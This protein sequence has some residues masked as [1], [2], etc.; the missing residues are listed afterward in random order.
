MSSSRTF[1]PGLS[2]SVAVLPGVPALWSFSSLSAIESCP[3]RYVL[4]RATYPD[5]WDRSGYPDL[6]SAAALF[7][8]VVHDSLE[9]IVRALVDHGCSSASSREAIAVL[10]KLGGYSEV[11]SSMLAKRLTRLEVNPRLS[12]RVRERLRDQLEQRIPEAREEIQYYLHRMTM[13]PREVI[14]PGSG[15]RNQRYARGVG[16]HPEVTLQADDLRLWGRIDLLTV[17]QVDVDITDY[18]TGTAEDS[19]FDQLRFYA[20]L[21]HQDSVSNGGRTPLGTLTASYPSREVTIAAPNTEQL[22]TLMD[23]LSSRVTTADRLVSADEPAA[24]PG[25]QCTFCDVRPL[26]SAYWPTTPDPFIMKRGTW[27]DFEGTVV[28]RNG[29]KSWWLH[30]LSPREHRL[31]LRTTSAHDVFEPGQHLRLL[32]LRRDEDLD[33]D[34][35]V[36]VLTQTSEAFVVTGASDY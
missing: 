25:D 29:I 27:F 9:M 18:K 26:C 35:A 31:L 28:G 32:G 21:W 6:P 20:V 17:G 3:R 30:D 2:D 33:G 12:G 19:H 22:R 13:T 23:E 24:R 5:L 15:G 11:A 10:R 7:G 36:A 4:S 34:V 8:D 16:S 1:D 14:G